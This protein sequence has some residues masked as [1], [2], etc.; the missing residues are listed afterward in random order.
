MRQAM[1][2]KDAGPRRCER[3]IVEV[4]LAPE[5]RRRSA[6]QVADS[7]GIAEGASAILG[8]SNRFR[9]REASGAACAAGSLVG[10][11]ELLALQ[12]P[13]D[14]AGAATDDCA[15]LMGFSVPDNSPRMTRTS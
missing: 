1:A 2:F 5:A 10:E 11:G 7:A 8:I 14:V 12:A 4:K 15:P 6:L 9:H 13:A 3:R